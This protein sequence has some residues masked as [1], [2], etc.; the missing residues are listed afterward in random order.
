MSLVQNR[1]L[2]GILRLRVLLFGEIK[3]YKSPIRIRIR[4]I[5]VDPLDYD[6]LG[7][8]WHHIYVDTCVPF[9]TK[10]GSKILQCC[11]DAVRH[12]MRQNG[13]KI[14]GYID[15]YVG[16]GVPSDAKASFDFLYELL[17][18]LGLTI[19]SKKLVPPST[20]V[21]CLGIENDTVAGSVSIPEEKL[22]KISE[23]VHE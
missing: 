8:S 4:H 3:R 5:K 10:H 13:H 19:S 11:S 2:K 14:V 1:H 7:L 17:G 20:K 6:L 18:R 9:G 22:Q 12:I 15:D 16:F 21:T 23:M